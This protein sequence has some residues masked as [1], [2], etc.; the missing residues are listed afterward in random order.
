MYEKIVRG[1]GSGSPLDPVITCGHERNFQIMLEIIIKR[2][3]WRVMSGRTCLRKIIQKCGKS[4]AYTLYL[5]IIRRCSM[6][7]MLVDLGQL[8]TNYFPSTNTLLDAV[9]WP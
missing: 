1:S 6:Q 9:F 7:N 3:F 2:Y 5:Q 8:L 4:K